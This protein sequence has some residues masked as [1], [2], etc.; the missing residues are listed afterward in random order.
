M[1]L[2]DVDDVVI[3]LVA[4]SLIDQIRTKTKAILV[5]IAVVA[6]L[7]IIGIVVAPTWGKVL[8]VLVLIAAVAGVVF[9][10]VARRAIVALLDRGIDRT[11][12]AEHRAAVDRAVDQFDIPSGPVSMARL[13]WRL[14]RGTGDEIERIKQVALQLQD[15]L[16]LA[17]DDPAPT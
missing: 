15:D 6:A 4:G 5:A 7:A 9:T 11:D 14:R 12:L 2:G 13:A 1:D 16:D 3:G 8:C 17:P 10:L